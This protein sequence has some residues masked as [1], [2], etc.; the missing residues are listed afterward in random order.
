MVENKLTLLQ[1]PSV[2]S[3]N[4]VCLTFSHVV[5]L[6]EHI[7]VEHRFIAELYSQY[8]RTQSGQAVMLLEDWLR[9]NR[10]EQ[11][12]FSTQL[13]QSTLQM[14]VKTSS[15]AL[16]RD[17][18]HHSSSTAWMRTKRLAHSRLLWR[19]I[20][21]RMVCGAAGT[22]WP[23]GAHSAWPCFKSCSSPNPTRLLTRPS[24]RTT[25]RS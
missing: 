10:V 17:R 12:P 3:S 13:P 4:Q 25:H 19:P 9:F 15:D 20:M 6:V 24:S 11:V 16:T 5:K 21:R 18:S 8:S 23:L 1:L 14:Q 2:T 7:R 22:Q